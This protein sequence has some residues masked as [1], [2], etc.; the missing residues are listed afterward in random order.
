MRIAF[1]IL[2]VFLALFGVFLL[3]EFPFILGNAI[4]TSDSGAVLASC[5]MAVMGVGF[6]FAGRHCVQLD[7]DAHDPALPTSNLIRFLVNHRRELKVLA[8]VGFMV[9]LIRLIAACFGSDWPARQTTGFLLI[10]AVALNYCGGKA[11][12]PGVR[13]NQDWMN[14][15]PGIR[16]ALASVLW[17]GS[18]FLLIYPQWRHPSSEVSDFVSRIVLDA[19]ITFMYEL[20]ALFFAYGE[21]RP[22]KAEIVPRDEV[23][24][25]IP[26][27]GIP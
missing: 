25:L 22:P 5:I 15:P 7:P 11:S 24:P 9:S 10:G 23:E 8:Q 6:L 18:A 17:L 12:N 16:R 2:G 19:M 4:K 14:V 3:S 1:I 20:A 13:G 26:P 21:L 27:P